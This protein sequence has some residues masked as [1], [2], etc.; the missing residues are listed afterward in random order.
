MISQFMLLIGV[1]MYIVLAF[2]YLKELKQKQCACGMNGTGYKV[3]QWHASIY[4]VA[5]SL[6]IA[7]PILF[8]LISLIAFAVFAII[9]YSKKRN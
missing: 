1:I 6:P 5:L 2:L 7:L 4:V 3:L 8:L 9:R